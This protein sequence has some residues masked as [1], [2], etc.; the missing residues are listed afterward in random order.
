MR[1]L[2][3]SIMLALLAGPIAAE[4]AR[5]LGAGI[6][7][8]PGSFLPERGP[9]GNTVILE[10]P[11]GLIVVDTGRHVWHSD[12]ILAFASAQK[13]PIRVIVNTHWHLDHSS[14]NGRLKSAFPDARIYTTNAVDRMLAPGGFLTRELENAKR[15]LNDTTL[16]A[17]QREEVAVFIKTMEKPDNLRPDVAIAKSGPIDLAGRALEVRVTDKAVTDA[18]MWLYDAKSGTAIIGDLVTLPVPFFETACPR[19]WASALDEVWATPF[20]LAVPGHGEP[21]TR[22]AFDSYRVAFGAF[23]ACVGSAKSAQECAAGWTSA[24][25]ALLGAKDDQRQRALRMSEYYVK[26]LRENGGK[27]KDCLAE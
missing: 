19:K 22:E 16:S 8:L 14:G 4:P 7:L 6:H 15:Y 18:D 12:A 23:V 3:A 5:D 11:E 27:S 25:G 17:T 24:I 13:R 10:A 2:V 9:D 1:I 26:M 21:M 20:K